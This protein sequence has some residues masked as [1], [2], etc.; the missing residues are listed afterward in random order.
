MGPNFCKSDPALYKKGKLKKANIYLKSGDDE[1][2]LNVMC[3]G[4]DLNRVFQH[5]RPWEFKIWLD[6]NDLIN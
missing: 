4:F 5:Y 2:C 3:E 1:M 6:Y